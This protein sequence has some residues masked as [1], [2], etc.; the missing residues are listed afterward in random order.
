[1]PTTKTAFGIVCALAALFSTALVAQLPPR[2]GETV[3]IAKVDDILAWLPAASVPKR[4]VG[5]TQPQIEAANTVFLKNLSERPV[6]LKMRVEVADVFA[7][8]PDLVL[9]SSLP[10]KEGYK[11]RLFAHFS[12]AWK[13]RLATIQK[14]AKVTVTAAL[15][16]LT[17][18]TQWNEFALVIGTQNSGFTK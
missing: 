18:K 5:W 10:N 9:F 4:G 1:M 8:E 12:Q 16:S 2:P 17:Y 15:T 11:I 6:V 13:D 14:G 3:T 7:Q